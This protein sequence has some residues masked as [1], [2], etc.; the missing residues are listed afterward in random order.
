MR[1]RTFPWGRTTLVGLALA[2]LVWP[3][4]VLVLAHH[5]GKSQSAQRL[6]S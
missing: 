5:F 4:L 3:V 2:G 1:S 6:R